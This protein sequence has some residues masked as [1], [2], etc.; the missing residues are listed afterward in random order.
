MTPPTPSDTWPAPLR[1]LGAAC[2][3]RAIAQ[4]GV[5]AAVIDKNTFAIP[6]GQRHPHIPDQ[7]LNLIRACTMRVVSFYAVDSVH[8]GEHIGRSGRSGC[9]HG[10]CRHKRPGLGRRGCRRVSP[11]TV[12]WPMVL[13][14]A[15]VLRTALDAAIDQTLASVVAAQRGW[16]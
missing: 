12:L 13:A 1:G 8:A 2:R 4:V 11:L 9:C 10:C 15:K 16:I 6:R 5:R 7:A 3:S 14:G